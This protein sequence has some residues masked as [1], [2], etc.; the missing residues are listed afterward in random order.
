MSAEV[1]VTV[2]IPDPHRSDDAETICRM[3]RNSA[4]YCRIYVHTIDPV[5]EFTEEAAHASRTVAR[6]MQS[7]VVLYLTN[8]SDRSSAG[9]IALR[10]RAGFT[11]RLTEPDFACVWFTKNR[12]RSLYVLGDLPGALGALAL[13]LEL[14]FVDPAAAQQVRD[15]LQQP[16][17]ATAV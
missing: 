13:A 17:L 4:P 10:E 16:A 1:R 9:L 12:K 3:L 6:V 5:S 15:G 11:S 7:D 14:G 2:V 8:G